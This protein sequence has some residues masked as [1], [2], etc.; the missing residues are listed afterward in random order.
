MEKVCS[1]MCEGY[2]DFNKKDIPKYI[3]TNKGL[4]NVYKKDGF[5]TELTVGNDMLSVVMPGK[6]C[7]GSPN[8]LVFLMDCVLANFKGIDASWL[9]IC[10]YPED[11]E[12][13]MECPVGEVFSYSKQSGKIRVHSNFSDRFYGDV[14]ELKNTFEAFLNWVSVSKIP[15]KVAV[16]YPLNRDKFSLSYFEG[17]D[18]YYLG[19]RETVFSRGLRDSQDFAMICGLKETLGEYVMAIVL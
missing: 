15:T 13:T 2:L 5:D 16:I 11:G 14:V 6:K 19:F 9:S 3:G 12:I 8:H 10:D 4:N 17:L 18:K 7:K 1:Y